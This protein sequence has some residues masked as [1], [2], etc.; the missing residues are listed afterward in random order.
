MGQAHEDLRK[1]T[2]GRWHQKK[3]MKCPVMQVEF[4]NQYTGQRFASITTSSSQ[5]FCLCDIRF[6]TC[7]CFIHPR[8]RHS[9]S[10]LHMWLH[11]Q[12]SLRFLS[13]PH[14]ATL[15]EASTSV[16]GFAKHIPCCGFRACNIGR[17]Q[18]FATD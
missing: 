11:H 18:P 12:C 6:V 8:P 17:R 3:N 16:A 15:P 7:E 5:S 4:L 14:P 9:F 10:H 2:S 13:E 1:S